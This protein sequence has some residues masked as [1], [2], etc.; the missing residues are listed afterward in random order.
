MAFNSF[1][2]KTPFQNQSFGEWNIVLSTWKNTFFATHSSPFLASH[3]SCW[4]CFIL[5]S[6]KISHVTNVIKVVVGTHS[7]GEHMCQIGPKQL[8][9]LPQLDG[10]KLW[11]KWTAPHMSRDFF[12]CR[13]ILVVLIGMLIM[14][15]LLQSQHIR[16]VWCPIHPQQPGFFHCW[17]DLENCSWCWCWALH[18]PTIFSHHLYL[19]YSNCLKLFFSKGCLS[20]SATKKRWIDPR[21]QFQL[22]CGISL[23][24]QNFRLGWIHKFT[25]LHKFETV[26]NLFWLEERELWILHYLWNVGICA[27]MYVETTR[28]WS[29]H[30]KFVCLFNI[31]DFKV[32]L[33]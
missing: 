6:A 24:I 29:P 8:G 14:V 10:T 17:L 16:V 15:Y 13:I 30:A 4:T 7:L 5:S 2:S 20:K 27:S 32:R 19:G 25:N 1:F 26:G 31:F 3:P 33:R 21:T 12:Y 18:E 22:F 9:T 23:E 28:D 11:K